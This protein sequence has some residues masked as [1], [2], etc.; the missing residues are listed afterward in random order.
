MYT[1]NPEIRKQMQEDDTRPAWA[2]LLSSGM[3]RITE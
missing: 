1:Y 2:I 3:A